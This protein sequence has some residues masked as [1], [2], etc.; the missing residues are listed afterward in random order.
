MST[1]ELMASHTVA[2]MRNEPSQLNTL[3]SSLSA[4]PPPQAANTAG[5]S[6][7]VTRYEI[8]SCDKLRSVRLHKISLKTCPQNNCRAHWG[9]A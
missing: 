7:T 5:A 2:H 4:A 3:P 8:P 6:T 9:Y 1:P